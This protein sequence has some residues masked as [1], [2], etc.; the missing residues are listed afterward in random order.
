MRTLTPLEQVIYNEG[1]R[2]IPGVTHDL[3]EVVRHRSSYLFFRGVMKRDWPSVSKPDRPVTIVDL[4][5]GVGHGCHALSALPNSQIVGVDSSPE[6]LEYARTHYAAANITYRLA[7]LEEF[8]PDMPEYDYVVSRGV[9]E[10]VRG[11]LRLAVSTKWRCR[12]LFDV[13]YDEPWQANPHHLL[14][15]IREE[16]FAEFKGVELFFQDLGGV[17]YDRPRKPAKP[18]M[19]ICVCS[20]PDLPPAAGRLRL[21]V[22]AWR[23]PRRLRE[24]AAGWVR[25]SVEQLARPVRKGLR[26]VARWRR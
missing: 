5:C 3:A 6:S 10:H 19:I 4:G 20:R 26:L 21:P 14:S 17:I 18:N 7:N 1:E 9:F 15:G 22:P 24:V 11:G 13:P 23:P 12:L 25:V 8:I 2:L 16:A